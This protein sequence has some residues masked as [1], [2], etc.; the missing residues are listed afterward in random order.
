MDRLGIELLSV[1]GMPP[2]EHVM[3]A[4]DLGC[5]Y[6]STGLTQLPFNPHRYPAWSLMEDPALR[7]EM[8]AA[9]RDRGVSISL[10]E[11]MIVRANVDIRDRVAEFDILA[12]LGA[13]RINTLGMDPDIGRSKDQI[14][15]LVDMA[16]QR[17]MDSTTEFAPGYPVGSLPAALEV[18]R[19]VGKPNFRLLIDS[20]HLMRS[21]GTPADLAALD[22]SLIGYAQISDVP[23][24]PII[25][26]YMQEAMFARKVPGTGELPLLEILDAL[27]RHIPLAI[28][29]P[30][31]KEAEAGVPPREVV[32]RCAAAIRDLLAR[33]DRKAR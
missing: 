26:D 6:I 2:V 3:L 17:G 28:E 1:L 7:R 23:L 32:G 15:I 31:L 8:I 18:V 30:I 14:A 10:G 4:A 11:G 27:P 16:A 21:G 25:A 29:V 33:L 9:M 20:M 24:K 12:E 19:H 22:P 13:E 5:K